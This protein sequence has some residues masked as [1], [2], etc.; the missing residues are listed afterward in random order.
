MTKNTSI[1]LGNH[2]DFFVKQR[3]EEGRFKNV[4]EVI[5]AGLRLLEDE[6]SKVVLLKNAIQEGIN[7]G[8]A[9]D[10]DPEKH[11]ESLKA[12]KFNG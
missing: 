9:I 6:E 2:F 5:R 10:F 4:S 3:I 8:I 12:G 11:L 7:S 1:S